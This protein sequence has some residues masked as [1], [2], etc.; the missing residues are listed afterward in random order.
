M[1]EHQILRIGRMNALQRIAHLLLE[2]HHRLRV[3]GQS[4][5][6]ARVLPVTQHH[7]ADA[8]GMTHVHANRSYRK[9]RD[10]GLLR[11][12]HGTVFLHDPR[13]LYR[14]CDFDDDYIDT[15][16]LAEDLRQRL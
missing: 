2:L 15:H 7:I 1:L 13:A 10:V 4:E 3:C 16:G 8:L 6:R 12:E 9:L 14:F 5:E 11:A